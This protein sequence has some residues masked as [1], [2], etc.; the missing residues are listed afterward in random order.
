[1][2]LFRFV[3]LFALLL[4]AG[5][6][7]TTANGTSTPVHP[8]CN[9]TNA[10]W[11]AQGYG[12]T[13]ENTCGN[14]LWVCSRQRWRQEPTWTCK[15]NPL[16]NRQDGQDNSIPYGDFNWPHCIDDGEIRLEQFLPNVTLLVIVC[17]GLLH[18]FY[19]M[20][21]YFEGVLEGGK[22]NYTMLGNQTMLTIASGLLVSLGFVNWLKG[23][24]IVSDEAY[25][26]FWNILMP[27]MTFIR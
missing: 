10:G 13:Q 14:R 1:M 24:G 17:C 25:T 15:C 26:H 20:Y 23:A 19:G 7:A 16:W 8:L 22:H 12:I 2:T 11:D 18:S 6:F 21:L 3:L 9:G 4:P 5:S 27:S